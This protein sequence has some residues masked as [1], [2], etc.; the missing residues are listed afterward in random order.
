MRNI[1]FFNISLLSILFAAIT[2]FFVPVS[3]A[4]IYTYSYTAVGASGNQGTVVG[5]FGYDTAAMDQEPS[6]NEGVYLTGFLNGTVTVSFPVKWT[7][8]K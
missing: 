3:L 7:I 1:E 5:T 8:E 4:S 2:F 6:L